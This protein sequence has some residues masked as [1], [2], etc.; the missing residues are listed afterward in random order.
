MEIKI[1]KE[2]YGTRITVE[3]LDK[4]IF[5]GVRDALYGPSTEKHPSINKSLEIVANQLNFIANTIHDK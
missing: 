2:E 5:K 3:G 4:E 1:Y